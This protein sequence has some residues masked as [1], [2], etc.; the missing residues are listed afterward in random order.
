MSE[1]QGV[2]AVG[3]PR[4][5]SDA[6]TRPSRSGC[7]NATERESSRS[8][9]RRTVIASLLWQG[10][11]SVVSQ[12]TSWLATLVVI[13]LLSPS[14]YGLMAMAGLSIGFLML[15]GD[16]GVGPVIVQAS[17]LKRPQLQALFGVAF[18]A[19]LLGAVVAF[20]SAPVAAAFFAE[21]RLVAIVRALSLS[22]VFAGLYAVPQ[23][24]VLRTLEFHRQA[25]IDV[26]ATLTS[27]IVALALALQGWGAWSLVAATLASQAFKAIAF[28]IVRPCLFLPLPSF[29]VVRDM[30]HFGGL[31][32][33]D[34]ILWFGYTN[35]DIAIA[36]RT[37]GG[38]LVGLY[39][40]ALSLASIPF[41][42]VMSIVTQVS[43][44]AFSRT[45]DDRESLRRG[46]LQ[47][48]EAVSLLAFPTFFGM[49]VVAPDALAVFV[50]PKWADAV[51]PFQILCLAL[52]FRSLGLLFA[53]ALFGTGRPRVAVENNAIMLASVAVAL[54]V[55]VQWGVVGLC[56]G[57]LVGYIP[58]FC[59]TAYR[60][61]ATLEM[62]V[63]EA[64]AVIGLPLAA[65]L[66]MSVGVVGARILL[67]EALPHDALP[68]IVALVSLSLLGAGI[69]GGLI[70]VF[71]PQLL[72][73]YWTLALGK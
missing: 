54:I 53:P 5:V 44:S 26:L 28:Q 16:L 32:T 72:R 7:P 63:G 45:Q 50:G 12:L 66:A 65:T 25:K 64:V 67:T 39:S 30:A 61:L 13:R 24:L 1:L 11:A 3:N 70:A 71:R 73:S 19:Y 46:M 57:W 37:L 43:F 22:F 20:A 56:V 35:L 60:T 40:V 27:S 42:K 8:P 6:G 41:D 21:P 48:L 51:L 14:D 69:Y 38:A 23:A 36:G 68:H 34:R 49:A 58:V 47:A 29:A 15:I 33:V 62:A 17:A 59:V 18:L 52:P 2:D 31:V 10:S 9:L 55:G 4:A